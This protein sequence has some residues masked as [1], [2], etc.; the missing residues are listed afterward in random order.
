MEFWYS[1]YWVMILLGI[2]GG[3][4]MIYKVYGFRVNIIGVGILLGMFL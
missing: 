2:F 3:N 1:L 4:I